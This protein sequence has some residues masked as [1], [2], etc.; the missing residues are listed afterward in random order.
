[1]RTNGV[2]SNGAAAKVMIFDRLGKKVRPGTFGRIKVG[3]RVYP[4]GPCQKHEICSD[5]ISADPIGPFPNAGDQNIHTL[6]QDD[7]RAARR[8]LAVVGIR[9][10]VMFM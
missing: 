6:A 4:N 9:P 3:S 8:A 5:P 10:V 1:M 7:G 2:N